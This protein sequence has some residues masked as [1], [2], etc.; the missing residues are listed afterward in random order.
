MELYTVF[1]GNYRFM[2]GEYSEEQKKINANLNEADDLVVESLFG[3]LNSI[4]APCHLGR[5]PSSAKPAL[6]CARLLAIRQGRSV[7]MCD[8][9]DCMICSF[10]PYKTPST[11]ARRTKR[12]PAVRSRK[13]R[14]SA[15][16][17]RSAL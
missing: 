7:A 9:I 11:C 16:L 12:R 4:R 5:K 17:E 3:H 14:I 6:R 13:S 2:E 8:L 10:K 1:R 15:I